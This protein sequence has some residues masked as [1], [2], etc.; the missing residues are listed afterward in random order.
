MVLTQIESL[1]GVDSIAIQ[2]DG[3]II[4]VGA[5]VGGTYAFARY[6]SDGSLD[7]SF[8]GT[9]TSF[10]KVGNYVW[11]SCDLALQSDRKIIVGGGAAVSTYS[12]FAFTRLNP[13]GSLDSSFGE[14]GKVIVSFSIW[15][16]YAHSIAIQRDGK[17]VAAGTDE[18]SG[19]A[20]VRLKSNGALDNT[21]NGTG[22]LST[23]LGGISGDSAS[24]VAIQ[25]DGNIVVVGGSDQFLEDY[26]N[27][28]LL[29]YRGGS[30]SN[31]RTP[32]DYD[33]DG[34]S[35]FSVWRPSNGYWHVAESQSGQVI[36]QQ[37]GLDGDKLAPADYDG[38]GVADKAIY[39]PSEGKWYVI[40]SETATINQITFG[41]NGDIPLPQDFDGDGKADFGIWR[42][43][44]GTWYLGLTQ[45]GSMYVLPFGLSTDKPV[46]ADY[47]GDGKCELAIWRPSEG[48]WY[49]A[50][51]ATGAFGTFDWG[52]NGDMPVV[53]DYS[54]DGKAD[55]SVYRPS[56]QTWYRIHTDDFGVRERQWG[57]AG[58]IPTPGDFDGDGKLD[59]AVFRPS[60]GK[61]YVLTATS[62]QLS[63]TFGLNGDVPT[64]SAFVY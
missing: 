5:S 58:D 29:R 18:A 2:T 19:I 47:D 8:N 26:Y 33:G 51:I 59:I 14:F 50:N 63:Q 53:G 48:R 6:N 55:Y 35:D 44:N 20:L 49:V 3:K 61:W 17:I 37:S 13:D 25:A 7:S 21:F 16:D 22:K 23:R 43:S 56:N 41:L 45:S 38:D 32:F 57:L 52:L 30:V 40:Y 54:G 34:K 39:R 12:D 64:E 62:A 46:P 24:S 10:T 9:G 42:P 28:F 36:S 60:E 11:G 27:L 1:G 4:C 31:S 15:H